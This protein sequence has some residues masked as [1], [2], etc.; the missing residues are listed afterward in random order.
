MVS[1]A[2]VVD[3]WPGHETT[4][5][6]GIATCVRDGRSWR[7]G[8]GGRRLLVAHSV[9]LL[10]LA[11][12]LANPRVDIP[13]IELVSGVAALA[14]PVPRAAGSAQPVLDRTAIQ[15]YRQRLTRL[16]DEIDEL[17]SAGPPEQVA[18]ARAERDWLVREMA[19]GVGLGGRSRDFTDDAERARLA[20]GRAIRRAITRIHDRDAII[21]GHLRARVHTGMRCCYFP[22]TT[23]RPDRARYA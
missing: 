13:A 22:A 4:V 23:T 5:D 2:V 1:T 6:G 14:Q 21:G 15:Q 9:G 17:E 12:L 3:A 10:H 20:A 7:V 8:L 11:V 19:A 18:R 16:R